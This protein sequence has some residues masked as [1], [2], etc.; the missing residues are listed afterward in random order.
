MTEPFRTAICCLWQGTD[1]PEWS[2]SQYDWK[3]VDALAW[4]LHRHV[5]NPRLVVLV[6]KYHRPM[7]EE[8]K[9]PIR[10]EVYDLVSDSVGGWARRMQAF[11]PMLWPSGEERFVTMDLDMIL[12]G[13]CTWLWEWNEAPVGLPADP[14][15]PTKPCSTI[16][17]Y[18]REGAHQ[19]WSYWK[20][21]AE[22]AK[23]FGRSLP[24]CCLYE[25]S[26]VTPFS[27]N[28]QW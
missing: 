9:A 14:F 22:S 16:V 10:I 4:G 19:I 11:S 7:L 27:K 3:Y 18:S 2:A 15:F 24:M 28:G 12:V 23:L 1:L 17:S 26:F 5:E 13:D 25:R 20:E 8:I 21:G 6:D